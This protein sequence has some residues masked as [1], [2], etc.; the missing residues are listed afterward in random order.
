MPLP[1]P[2]RPGQPRGRLGQPGDDR[3]RLRGV[4]EAALKSEARGLPLMALAVVAYNLR[5]LTHISQTV[6]I[7]SM[8]I[9]GL[10]STS[11]PVCNTF[12]TNNI[13]IRPSIH[14]KYDARTTYSQK[15]HGE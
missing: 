14:P 7:D 2:D 5:L 9:N 4:G 8:V 12:T 6:G 15:D 11:I 3:R 10:Y 1:L 13:S